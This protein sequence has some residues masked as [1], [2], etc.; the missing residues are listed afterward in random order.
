MKEK[1]MR[2]FRMNSGDYNFSVKKQNYNGEVEYL[3][4]FDD[5][6]NLIG[7]GKTIEEAIKEANDNLQAY[8]D[9]C[10]QNKIEYPCPSE[11]ELKEN[12][13]SG[14]VTLRMSKNLHQ[15]AVRYAEEEG[16]SLN[17]FIN[18][19][20]NEHIS[21]LKVN[22]MRNIVDEIKEYIFASAESYMKF[23]SNQFNFGFI[24]NLNKNNSLTDV[25]Y[26]NSSKGGIQKGCSVVYN[27]GRN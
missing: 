14:K 16:V 24:W 4:I 6:P 10:E 27:D 15:L 18:D 11:Y 17:S 9:Y 2:D 8:I 7:A 25:Q 22:G 12:F 26:L 21:N 13:Y 20:I 1:K 23:H 19:S 3:V 5:F